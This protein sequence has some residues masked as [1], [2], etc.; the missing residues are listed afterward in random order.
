MTKPVNRPHKKN[1]RP[2]KLAPAGAAARIEA[3]AA[4]GFS[5]LGVAR[6]LGTSADTF[7]RWL[8]EVPALREAFDAGRETERHCLHNMLYRQAMEKGNASAAMFLLKARHGYREGDQNDGGNRVQI[9]FTL[10]GAMSMD[11]FKVIE[12]G[13][14]DNRDQRLPT[15]SLAVTRGG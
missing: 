5:V 6:A 13:T 4:D 9:T 7:R 2:L 15:Q 8:D 10:P 11:D 1:G 14:A 3:L 12:N